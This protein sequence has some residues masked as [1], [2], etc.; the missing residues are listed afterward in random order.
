MKTKK[1]KYSKL[2]IGVIIGLLTSIVGNYFLVQF[3]NS[4]TKEQMRMQLFLD[5]KH[6]FVDACNDYLNLYRD[7]HELMNFFINKDELENN[8]AQFK[9]EFDSISASKKYVEWKKE[10]DQSYGRLLLLSDNDFGPITMEVST[11]LHAALQSVI[12]DDTISNDFKHKILTET[13][14]YF[15]D[16]WLNRAK[17]EISNYNKGTRE[18]KTLSEYNDGVQKQISEHKQYDAWIDKEY[19]GFKASYEYLKNQDKSLP[20]TVISKE[21]FRKMIDEMNNEIKH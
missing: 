1:S 10:F 16:T 11:R 17:K 12:Y 3:Q 13:D 6:L 14:Y 2:I 7:W 5:E 9:S 15:I 20:D 18:E 8:S 19:E 21:E 4:S